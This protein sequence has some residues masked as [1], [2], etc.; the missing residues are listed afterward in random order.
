MSDEV[1]DT[2]SDTVETEI[3]RVTWNDAGLAPVIVQQYDT[4]EVL[5]HK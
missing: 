5:M 1:N 4:R 3:A 2:V